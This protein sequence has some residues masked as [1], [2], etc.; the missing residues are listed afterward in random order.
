MNE[1][2]CEEPPIAVKPMLFDIYCQILGPQGRC[3]IRACIYVHY[4]A[5]DVD[6]ALC[7]EHLHSL[8]KLMIPI[9][10]MSA[11]HAERLYKEARQF[12]EWVKELN[13]AKRTVPRDAG[14]VALPPDHIPHVG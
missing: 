14:A 9:I 10:D 12:D 5:F 7:G 8:P 1:S 3:P 11:S 13:D 2:C 6:L 4:P